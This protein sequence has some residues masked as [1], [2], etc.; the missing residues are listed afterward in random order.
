MF[1]ACGLD[2]GRRS[3]YLFWMLRVVIEILEVYILNIIIIRCARPFIVFD[4]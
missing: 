4:G 1:N 3:W 2:H